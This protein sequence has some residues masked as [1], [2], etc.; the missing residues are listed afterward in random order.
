MLLFCMKIN[1]ELPDNLIKDEPIYIVRMGMDAELLAIKKPNED[2]LIKTSSCNKCGK[3]C[4]N[5]SERHPFE[6]LSK[7]G[8]CIYLI[9]QKQEDGTFKEICDLGIHIPL[10]CLLGFHE[11]ED[12]PEFCTEKFK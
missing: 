11:P 10:A 2:W 1:L 5:L 12:R 7:D 9:K 4:Y 6:R 8:K 3:C